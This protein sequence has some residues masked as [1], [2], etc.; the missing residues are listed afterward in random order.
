VLDDT[1][2]AGRVRR[3]LGGCPVTCFTVFDEQ[4]AGQYWREAEALRE[5]TPTFFDDHAQ[6]YWVVTRF[7]AVKD[8]H[9]RVDLFSS[10]SFMA[11]EPNPPYR[12]VP[13]RID[14]PEHIKY[15][16]LLNPKFSPGAGARA[17]E[18]AGAIARQMV[19]EIDSIGQ[20]DFVAEFGFRF[21]TEVFLTVVGLPPRDADRLVPC[22]ESFFHG[23]GAEDKQAGMVAALEGI[24]RYIVDVVA[25]RRAERGDP[26][27]DLV[28]H[29]LV[30]T[31]DGEPLTDTVLLDMCT[32]L[33]LAGLDTTRGQLGYLFQYLA[34][35]PDV[36][37]QIL[38]DPSL[39]PAC[40]EE[41]LR[42]HSITT[43]D[44]RKATKDADFHGCP[45]KA[46]DMV[47]GPVS[48]DDSDPVTT[49]TPHV[50]PRPQGRP[51]LRVRRET[52]PPPRRPSRPTGD[53]RR[54]Q[55][56]ARR[57]PPLSD[58]DRRAAGRARGPVH[59][60]AAATRL[61]HRHIGR[62]HRMKLTIDAAMCTGHGRC[63][64]LAPDLL[65]YDDEGFVTQRGTTIDVPAGHEDA[66]RDAAMSCP[67]GAIT[68]DG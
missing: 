3:E 47:M 59:P 15:R 67:E 56:V 44:A 36:R 4:V 66:A 68:I 38:A 54:R 46:G 51:P 33:V 61:G 49:R 62:D 52:A 10:E 41:S 53:A 40:I 24:R 31:V 37:Q 42:M 32:V 18:P 7:E 29:P 48:A 60:A 9:Q 2:D 45:V 43:V 50:P 39:V 23:L 30:S 21:P 17:E 58:R 16:E 22:V 5:A 8:L 35:H 1:V 63:Y 20:C 55:G 14:P 34:E 12:F 25:A 11:W 19:A 13:T 65:S 27:I 64:T 57:Y 28:S 6:G 26:A